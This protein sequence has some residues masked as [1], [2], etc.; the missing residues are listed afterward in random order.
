MYRSGPGSEARKDE[1]ISY[2]C[3]ISVLGADIAHFCVEL[4]W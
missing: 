1:R 2:E 3:A 4:N